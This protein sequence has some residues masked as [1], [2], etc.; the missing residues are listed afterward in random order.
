MTIN[1]HDVGDLVRVSGAFTNAAGAAAD[2][3]ALTF[4]Y[5]P[6]SGATVT[7]TYGTDAALVKDSTGNYHVDLDLDA[8]GKWFWRWAATG[9]AQ[10]AGQGEFD[11]QPSGF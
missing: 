7:L 8:A 3:S 11:A 6:P 4:A 10:G 2:P 9:T 1:V 5:T